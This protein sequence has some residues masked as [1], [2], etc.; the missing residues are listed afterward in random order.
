MEEF[1]SDTAS[2]K[3]AIE[4]L[5]KLLPIPGLSKEEADVLTAIRREVL[6]TGGTESMM[7]D[8][9]AQKRIPGGG[10]AGNLIVKLPG[11]VRRPRRLLMAHVDTVPI[12]A[13]CEPAIEG[14][15]VVSKNPATGLGGDDRSG[16]TVILHTLCEI[17]SRKLPHPPLT[18]LFAVQ[19]EIGLYGARFVDAGKLGAPKLC[20][21]WDGGNSASLCVG[22]T[23]DI[24][25][26]ITIH[27]IPS[28]AGVHPE[29][30]VNA[31][32]IAAIAIA[33]LQANGWL[34]LVKKGR[35]QGSSNI[36]IIEAGA[37]TNVVTPLAHLKA[38]ARSHD[39]AFR[40]KI[41]AEIQKAFQRSAKQLTSADGKR[42]RIEFT[43]ELKYEAF[44]L[45]DDEPTV[46][47]A[48]DALRAAGLTPARH[49]GNGGLD[50][51]WM[52]A[53][54]F[55]TVTLGCGQERI[56]TADERLH[57][58]SF[59]KACQTALHLATDVSK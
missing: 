53:H 17:L 44:R 55:P 31:I 47:A 2:S 30:G 19:E 21:N 10:N 18:F 3:R 23:G 46:L 25:M 42:G 20:F 15:Y 32:T 52:S 49:V 13:G 12:C 48:E 33:E 58:P 36:G 29:L 43:S 51:N 41:V 28:H 26:Q 34:G 4:R 40:L 24:A 1:T 59:L 50:A 22:A 27:G 39:P 57:V 11:T 8:D 7:L 16:T 54:G 6:A 45:N 9:Q 14:D 5:L 35:K 38:E 37:A 56:H